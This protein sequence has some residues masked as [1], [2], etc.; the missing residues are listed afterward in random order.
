[1]FAA[2][3]VACLMPCFP[4]LDFSPFLVL[5]FLRRHPGAGFMH[6]DR[7]CTRSCVFSC[8]VCVVLCFGS[9]LGLGFWILCHFSF[10]VILGFGV[11]IFVSV[12][13]FYRNL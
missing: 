11:F 13:L 3:F 12:S 6:G 8:L 7:A 9:F 1:M 2:W 4:T 10:C 5:L